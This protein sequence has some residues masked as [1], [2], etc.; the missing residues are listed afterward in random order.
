MVFEGIKVFFIVG[1]DLIEPSDGGDDFLQ[2]AFI[3]SLELVDLLLHEVQQPF[4]LHNSV[5]N[6]F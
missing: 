6:A 3:D 5:L 4:S 2:L 1:F